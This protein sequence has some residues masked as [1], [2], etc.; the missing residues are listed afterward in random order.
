MKRIVLALLLLLPAL[1]AQAQSNPPAAA[2]AQ[3]A[4]APD[5][6]YPVI[7]V[8]VVSYLQYLAELENRDGFN[9]FDITRAY[10][11]VNGQL[12]R[13]VRFRFTPDI[14][15]ATDGSLAGSLT[16][17]LKYAF[18]QVDNLTPG[19][20]LRFGLQ[21]TPWI[22]F[23]QSINRYRVQGTVFSERDALLPSSADF[24]ASYQLPF[25]SNAVDLH[26]G[27]FNGEG[28]SQADPNK[29]K[30]VQARVTVRPFPGRGNW[31][32]LRISGFV[33]G[34]WY[35]EDRPRHLG[36]LMASFEHTHVA[37]T[38]QVLKA[39]ERPVATLPADIDRDGS[40]YFL[41]V[42]QGLAGWAGLVRVD[43]FDPDDAIA[44]NSQRRII[45]GGAYWFQWPR[46]VRIG[47][48]ATDEQVDY[49][50]PA[51]ADEHRFLFQSHIEF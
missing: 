51:R 33:N 7:R 41:E 40:S 8:G 26:A 45:G 3:P 25:L 31:N 38:A 36:I 23:E 16:L 10:L 2:P 6:V 19:G 44:L 42:R 15:R 48:V 37:A 30:S 18:G 20:A 35:A 27:I 32:G 43:Q 46:G 21:P 11:N 50:A 13:N 39:V 29:Y 4:A 9:A 12:S 24:G 22:D 17:R 1:P 5:P 49:V 28:S 34:G 47:L 14:R